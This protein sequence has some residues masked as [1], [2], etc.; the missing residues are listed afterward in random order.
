MSLTLCNYDISEVFW[1]DDI[2]AFN[3]LGRSNRQAVKAGERRFYPYP[4]ERPGFILRQIVNRRIGPGFGFELERLP[5][6]EYL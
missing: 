4:L 1:K 5:F 3:I 2:F 6:G